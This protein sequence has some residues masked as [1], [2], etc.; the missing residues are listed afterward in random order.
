MAPPEVANYVVIHELAHLVIPHHG[1]IFWNLVE[2][3]CPDRK[4][5]QRWLRDNGSRLARVI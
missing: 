4:C 3:H 2:T 1:P 5:H